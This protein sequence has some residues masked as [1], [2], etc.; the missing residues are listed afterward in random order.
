MVSA[1]LSDRDRAI[2]W[3]LY[4]HRVLTSVQLYELFFPSA[5]RTRKRLL[6]LHRL[7]VVERFQPYREGGGAHPFHYLLDELGARVVASERGLEPSELDWTRA[8]ALKLAGSPQLRHLVE[9]NGFFTRLALALR[10]HPTLTLREWWGQLHCARLWGDLV[11]ADGYA[12]LADA[13]AALELW[14]EWDRGTE[15]HARL[16]EKLERYAD[17]EAALERRVAVAIVTPT[18]GREREVL[19]ALRERA[20]V[21]VLVTCAERHRAD[22]LARNW[23]EPDREPRLSLPDLAAEVA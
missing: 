5:H 4:E 16:A 20:P 7:R 9:A 2:C 23:L 12:Q 6:L 13:G 10:R 3:A 17:L 8:R 19:H 11:R 18:A 22:P 1:H 14:L 15:T 21:R